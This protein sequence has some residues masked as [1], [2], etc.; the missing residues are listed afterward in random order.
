MPF[1]S[2]KQQAFFHSAAALKAGI[3][4]QETQEFDDASK[5]MD[6]PVRSKASAA[7]EAQPAAVA[8]PAKAKPH[9][10]LPDFLKSRIAVRR[11]LG[12]KR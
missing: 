5:G 1:K 2:Q 8:A 9:K 7:P 3:T 10:A 12:K 6:L 11:A 4:P